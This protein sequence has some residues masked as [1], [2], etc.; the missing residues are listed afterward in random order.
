MDQIHRKYKKFRQP[1]L[2]QSQFQYLFHE[3][4]P[5]FIMPDVPQFRPFEL[6]TDKHGRQC[7]RETATGKICYNLDTNVIEERLVNGFY[8]RPKD[9]V[10]DIKAL[11]KDATNFGDGD[12]SLKSKELLANVEVDLHTMENDPKFAECESLYLRQLQRAKERQEK[13]RKE[14]V[15]IDLVQSD[16]SSGQVSSRLNP[17]RVINLG[18]AIPCRR[19]VSAISPFQT[20]TAPLSNGHSIASGSQQPMANGSSVP[21]RVGEDVMMSGTHDNASDYSQNSP[22]LPR[23]QWPN[24]SA[25]GP[26]S[27]SNRAT[28][29]N[30][31]ISA[32][33]EISHDASPS[34]LI[35][36]ASPTTSGKRTS[37]ATTSKRTSENW[38]IQAT[39]GTRPG[40]SSPTDGLRQDADLQETHRLSPNQS[41]QATD[42]AQ[43]DNS[44]SGEWCHSQAHAL[45]RGHLGFA[46]QTPS[47]HNS[48]EKPPVP[49]FNAP[50]RPS[51]HKPSQSNDVADDSLVEP[52]S[53]QSSS[54]KQYI[55][56]EYLVNDLLDRITDGSSGCSVEQLEQIY[57][58]LM[59]LIWKMRGEWN[60]NKVCGDLVKV[61]NETI[62]DIEAM[63]KVLKPSQEEDIPGSPRSTQ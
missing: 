39:N 17:T 38:S 34:A 57:R 16:V 49:P 19:P 42:L 63:Q 61:F 62:L 21:S 56:T 9:F 37:E 22:A 6:A 32:F 33:Q 41:T 51:T 10:A 20:P 35:N 40:A 53:T 14:I 45:A 46:S 30:S 11:V 50:L 27:M 43:G 24:S 4:D 28:G 12:R 44:V 60:R 1:V 18:E 55:I 59:D 52:N 5:N 23:Q 8:A 7:L 26:S 36:N 29:F 48:Q 25:V 3:K 58:E 13:R 15:G 54:P 47:T 2:Q 31:Q